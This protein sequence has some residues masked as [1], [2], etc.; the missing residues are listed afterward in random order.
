ML[1]EKTRIAKNIKIKDL[2]AKLS[3][4]SSLM[5]RILSN[6]RKPSIKQL[7]LLSEFLEIDFNEL[8]KEFLAEEILDVLKE[9]PEIAGDVLMVAEERIQYL[10]G[11]DRF[12]TITLSNQFNSKLKK[13]DELSA[14]WKSLKPL[15]EVQLRKMEEYFF[16]SYTYESNRI[17]GNTLTLQETHLVINEGI[18]IGGKSMREHLELV[19][20]KEAIELILELVQN[21]IPFNSFRLKQ[22]HQLILKGVDDRNAGIYRNLPVR[23]SGSSHVPPEPYLI[24]KM[25]EDYFIFYETQKDILHP[26]VLAAEMHERLV[27]IHP[28]IDGNGRTSRLVMNLILLKNGFTIANLKGNFDDRMRYYKALEQVQVNH[29]SDMFYELIAEHVESSLTEHLHLAGAS[30]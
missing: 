16:T 15:N 4:D 6:K 3:I 5:S 21:K 26:V 14:K 13:L 29:E 12:K 17:E 8:M 30:S 2:A 1:L 22:I 9:Y 28:F 23:I 11:K 25:M 24:E 18:T 10:S 20:H 27:T 7:K 19:N